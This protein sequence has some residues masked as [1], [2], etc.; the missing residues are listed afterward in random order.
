MVQA[1]PLIVTPEGGQSFNAIFARPG[2][3]FIELSPTTSWLTPPSETQPP[4]PRS[5]HYVIVSHYYTLAAAGLRSWVV[6]VVGV[7]HSVHTRVSGREAACPASRPNCRFIVP[8]GKILRIVM[9]EF[10][11][12]L[13]DFVSL[14]L[15]RVRRALGEVRVDWEAR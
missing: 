15:L 13:A 6:P 14:D 12:A 11:V 2:A 1:A 3:V 10:S 4:R 7:T 5:K 9:R 8:P